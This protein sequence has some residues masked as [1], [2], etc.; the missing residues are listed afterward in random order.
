MV[1]PV[2]DLHRTGIDVRLERIH[3]VGERGEFVGHRET[4]FLEE[5]PLQGC[6]LP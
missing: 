2:V 6:A 5:S 1:F 4:S 3:G